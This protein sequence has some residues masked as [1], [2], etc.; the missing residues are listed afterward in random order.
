MYSSACQRVS[1]LMRLPTF[2][3]PATAPIVSSPN[4]RAS[5]RDGIGLEMGIG[6]ESDDDLAVRGGKSRV[7][8]SRLAAVCHR[9]ERHARIG[10]EVLAHDI[11][12]AVGRSVVDDD[13]LELGVPAVEDPRDR[14]GDDLG[15][16][17]GRYQHGNG[18]AVACRKRRRRRRTCSGSIWP[19]RTAPRGA[20]GRGRWR[21]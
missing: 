6:V 2:A 14:P 21:A 20:R 5:S 15:F 13:H 16:V 1:R 18:D 17:E 10:S 9:D 12:G 11:A 19:V 3:L 4:Q 7:D 8:R